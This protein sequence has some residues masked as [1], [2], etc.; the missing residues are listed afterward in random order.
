[1]RL[2]HRCQQTCQPLVWPQ[3]TSACA[4]SHPVCTSIRWRCSFPLS[5]QQ[6]SFNISFAAS[7]IQ[8]HLRPHQDDFQL[9]FFSTQKLKPRDIRWWTMD[10]YFKTLHNVIVKNGGG[11]GGWM[12]TDSTPM[13]A[14]SLLS[15]D[16][17]NKFLDVLR[18]C[19]V[20]RKIQFGAECVWDVCDRCK[21]SQDSLC[22]PTTA[23]PW[24]NG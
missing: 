7:C 10:A 12:E 14:L 5:D 2:S 13:R 18:K 16:S 9:L 17:C 15:T 1:M 3:V 23:V 11:G 20:N 6:C 21:N 24:C 19:R 8:R 4:S 22:P